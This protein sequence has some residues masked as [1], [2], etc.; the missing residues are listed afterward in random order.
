VTGFAQ[1]RRPIRVVGYPPDNGSKLPLYLAQE[2]GIFERNGLQVYV[3]DPGSNEK[4]YE[5]EENGAADI[6]VVSAVNVV[7]NSVGRANLVLVANTGYHYFRFMTDPS[8]AK[9]EDLKGKRV[10]TSP[11]G[12]AAALIDRIVLMKLG[13]DPD[14][15]VEFVLFGQSSGR[16]FGKGGLARVH[17]LISGEISATAVTTEGILELEKLGLNSEFRVLTDYEKLNVYTGGGGDYAVSRS[18]LRES[19]DKVKA[20]LRSICEAIALA[21]KDRP[22]AKET[23]AKTMRI[24]DPVLLDFTYR[25]YVERVIPQRPYVRPESIEFALRATSPDAVAQGTRAQDLVDLSL[26]RELESE[27]LFEQLYR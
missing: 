10:A 9:P 7:S 27:G 5:A 16:N 12:S 18:F 25:T 24:E 26:I 14:R 8:V 19:R 20:F 1:S 4:L 13:L 11:P 2:A 23:L 22:K 21:R 3:H 6:Y 15:D 17:A